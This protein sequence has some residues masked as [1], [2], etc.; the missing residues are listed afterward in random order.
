VICGTI[1]MLLFYLIIYVDVE[2]IRW[3]FRITIYYFNR[4]LIFVGTGDPE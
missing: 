1:L 4:C 2:W 3:K